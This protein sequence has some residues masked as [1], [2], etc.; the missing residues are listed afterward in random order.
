MRSVTLYNGVRVPMIGFGSS[1]IDSLHSGSKKVTDAI[2]CALKAGYRH[3][4]T[5]SFY[6]N[7]RNVGEAIKQSG[8]MRQDIVVTTKM[9]RNEMGYQ[10]THAAFERSCE[11]LGLEYVDIYL[12]HW[13]DT[14]KNIDTWRA[15]EELYAN[16][17]VRA[18]GL[19]NFSI[20]DITQIMQ[21]TKVKPMCNQVELHPYYSQVALRTACADLNIQ[22]ISYSPLGTG[23]WSGIDKKKKPVS[24]PIILEIAAI[25]K[26]SAPQ[27]ILAWNI[28]HGLVAIPK[29]ENPTHIKENIAAEQ[30][31]LSHDEMQ[32]IDALNID[33][34][35]VV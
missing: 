29:S 24:N 14:V 2:L 16:K 1:A 31:T 33:K 20:A 15:L 6:E 19:S 28:A 23:T 30:L 3:I 35:F 11:R 10:E 32:Q 27:I 17:L 22:I 34:R 13:P 21:A 5:A 25:H 4:D 7:E 8:V 12:I 26:V 9:W 18:I